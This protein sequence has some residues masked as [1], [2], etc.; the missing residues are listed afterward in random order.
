M[1][2]AHQ[3]GSKPPAW[4]PRSFTHWADITFEDWAELA[5]ASNLY[6]QG[7]A[8]AD[9]PTSSSTGAAEQESARTSQRSTEVYIEP[10]LFEFEP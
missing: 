8:S 1:Q 9:P 3:L 5:L 4:L 7:V 2:S 6:L 10:D